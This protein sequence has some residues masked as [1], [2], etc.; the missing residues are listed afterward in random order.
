MFK[1]GWSVGT[2]FNVLKKSLLQL[3]I[4][5]FYLNTFWNVIYTIIIVLKSSVSHDADLVLKKHFLLLS[6]LKT[7]VLLNNFVETV[8]PPHPIESS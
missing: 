8:R 3:E 1:S 6:M 2:I 4:T 5:V 7:V